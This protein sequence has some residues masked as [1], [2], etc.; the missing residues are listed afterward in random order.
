MK[1]ESILHAI[2]N[3]PLVRV[4]FDAPAQVYA[5]LESLN[6]S[7]SVKDRSAAYMIEQAERSGKLKPG[8]T[9]IEASSG[10]QGIAT[11]L[12]GAIKGYN[13]II[14][15]AEKVSTEKQ[16]TLTAYGAKIVVCKPTA[17]LEDPESYY[18]IARKIHEETPNSVF[19]AQY[20][21]NDNPLGHYYS[22]GQEIWNQTAGT[23]THFI[24]GVGSGGTIGGVSRYLKERN[25]KIKVIGVDTAHSYRATGGNPKPYK[26][27]GI[28][29]DYTSP[30]IE[31]AVIDEF[32]NVAD[33]DSLNM[34]KA[35]ARK[36]GFLVGPASG[37]TAYA[38]QQYAEKLSPNDLIVCIFGDSG[39]AYLTKHFYE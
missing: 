21:N 19:L 12:I 22:L 2:G 11:A 16:Q 28:G 23:L 17:T 7:G 8:G 9:I 34:T 24:T 31:N 20:Y 18:E 32:F 29:I 30:H 14:T 35:L 26:I 37:A 3:T 36:Y 5:K 25:P 6:P 1:Y 4:P 15:V 33:E 27:E 13:V 39:R 10:N 38:V